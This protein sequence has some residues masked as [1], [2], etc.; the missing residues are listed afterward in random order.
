[1]FEMLRKTGDCCIKMLAG[2]GLHYIVLYREPLLNLFG[3]VA[4]TQ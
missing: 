1:M 3:A 4:G 2:I